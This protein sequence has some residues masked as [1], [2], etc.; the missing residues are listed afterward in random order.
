[1]QR[2]LVHMSAK[3]TGTVMVLT[4]DVVCDSPA[5]RDEAGP[6]SDRKEPPF[7]EEYVDHIGKAHTAL[8]SDYSR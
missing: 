1:M 5:H 7:G 4:V 8:A 2:H 6:R 3:G